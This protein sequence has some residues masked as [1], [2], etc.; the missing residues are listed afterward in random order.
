MTLKEASQGQWLFWL[1]AS[2]EN[3]WF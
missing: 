1:Q 2:S 3:Q